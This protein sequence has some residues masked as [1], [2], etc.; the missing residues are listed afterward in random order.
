MAG[1]IQDKSLAESSCV[2][3]LF[4][5]RVL[6]LS[7]ERSSSSRARYLRLPP[8]PAKQAASRMLFIKPRVSSGTTATRSYRSA[9]PEHEPV[10]RQLST[11][12]RPSALVDRPQSA[13]IPVRAESS[14]AP[15]PTSTRASFQGFGLGF[16]ALAKRRPL[17]RAPSS[18]GAAGTG[19]RADDGDERGL[20]ST[21][22]R[23]RSSWDGYGTTRARARAAFAAGVRPADEYQESRGDE[24][25]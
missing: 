21:D 6:H 24:S 4:S 10:S 3:L 5:P 13:E 12:A 20:R 18:S 23:S 2:S 8:A 16:A 17:F 25:D 9:S 11:G 22:G 7:T 15:S 19:L 1:E 14:R